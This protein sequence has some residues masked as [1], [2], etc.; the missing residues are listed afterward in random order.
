MNDDS[1]RASQKIV[2][3]DRD[4]NYFA[5]VVVFVVV[6]DSNLMEYSNRTKVA[7]VVGA[8][9]LSSSRVSLVVIAHLPH[10]NCLVAVVVVAVAMI[11]SLKNTN[12]QYELRNYNLKITL[13]N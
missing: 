10:R 11:C 1:Q 5:V 12:K 9:V 13:G 7:V 2:T 6:D 3:E 4:I 8:V